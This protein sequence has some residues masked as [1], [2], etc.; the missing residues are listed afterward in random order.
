MG[1]MLHERIS[2]AF[3]QIIPIVC[4]NVIENAL[5][6]RFWPELIKFPLI[7]VCSDSNYELKALCKLWKIYGNNQKR[8]KI[9]KKGRKLKVSESKSDCVTIK[10]N[11]KKR[12]LQT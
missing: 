12:L 1:K 4:Q 8:K 9:M 2:P 7:Y 3:E 6:S 10:C 11:I 5:N